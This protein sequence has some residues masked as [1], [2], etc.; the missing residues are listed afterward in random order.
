MKQFVKESFTLVQNLPA[1]RDLSTPAFIERGGTLVAGRVGSVVFLSVEL[2]NQ[3]A[4]GIEVKLATML[5]F[6][7][8]DFLMTVFSITLGILGADDCPV[9]FL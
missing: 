1:V 6:Y 5:A 8:G 9:F 4:R 3:E 2:I 7:A